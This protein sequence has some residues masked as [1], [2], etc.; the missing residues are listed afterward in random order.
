MMGGMKTLFGPM[1]RLLVALLVVMVVGPVMAADVLNGL[2]S[3]DVNAT[4]GK[5]ETSEG[6]TERTP[7]PGLTMTPARTT[8]L[9]K[10]SK[11]CIEYSWS[12][13][14][15]KFCCLGSKLN[16]KI[17]GNEYFINY[18]EPSALIEVSCRTGY[19]MINPGKVP[20]RGGGET[21]LQSCVGFNKPGNSRWFFEA[22]V[23]AINGEDGGLRH[24]GA[25][26]TNG[27]RM[28]QCTM[29]KTPGDLPWPGYKDNVR[30]GYGKKW[31]DFGSNVGPQTGPAGSWEAYISDSDQ[32]WALDAGSDSAPAQ[33]ACKIGGV[34][35]ANCW[36]PMSQNGWVS[37][38]NPRVAAALV[39]WRAHDKALK[40]KKVSPDGGKGFQ[41]AMEYPWIK[42]AGAHGASM[43]FENGGKTGSECFKP[44]D[45]G[46]AWFGG[47]T[48]EEIPGLV[49]GL[50]P[51]E[52]ATVSEINPGVY[53]FTVWVYTK[54]T[55][56]TTKPKIPTPKCHYI[57]HN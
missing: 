39:A 12:P 55:R 23:W 48:P 52:R 31:L 13:G 1:W 46:P 40:A 21:A 16:C 47:K 19:S 33:K 26:G 51:G 53:L 11:S 3:P 54:C 18:W 5:L 29:E 27:E 42:Y 15:K 14:R 10:G 56:W 22:R 45:S 17:W 36:G 8:D 20:T 30:H 2:E 7:L 34:D 32:A 38:P 28:R 57:G 35:L 9:M 6:K 41:M 25:G 4:D 37:H 44:G 24:Q 49:A 43:G 50:Q